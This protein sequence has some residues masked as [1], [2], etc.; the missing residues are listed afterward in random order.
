MQCWFKTCSLHRRAIIKCDLI[1]YTE[2]LYR[3]F[4]EVAVKNFLNYLY[5]EYGEN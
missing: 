1:I 3:D 2:F 4:L 5:L